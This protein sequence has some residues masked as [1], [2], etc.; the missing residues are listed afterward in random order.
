M[1]SIVSS[2]S[3]I[4][5]FVHIYRR[6]HVRHEDIDGG[7][8]HYRRNIR[9]QERFEQQEGRH[10]EQQEGYEQWEGY[11]Q[12]RERYEEQQEVDDR[13]LLILNDTNPP[14]I[15]DAPFPGW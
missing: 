2:C 11:E 6:R 3:F 15:Y 7:N 13:R 4:F 12:Q 5:V 1:W 10:E 9:E 14:H 8:V